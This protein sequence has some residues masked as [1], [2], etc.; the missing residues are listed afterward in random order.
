MGMRPMNAPT[1]KITIDPDFALATLRTIIARLRLIESEATEIGLAL[2]RG[3]ISAE[4]A[5]TQIEEIA[6]G[7]FGAAA[8]S[9]LEKRL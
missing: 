3:L 1:P 8:S 9:V 7:C 5:I 2:K 4:T 6:P